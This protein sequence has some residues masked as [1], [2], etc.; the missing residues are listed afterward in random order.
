MLSAYSPGW[1]VVRM[2]RIMY[3]ESRCQ[4]GARNTSSSATGLLQILA[5]HCGW[6]SDQMNTW[7][8]RDRLTNPYFN[9]RAAATLWREQS[10]GAWSTS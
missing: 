1:D 6:L 3:R 9:V 5:S 4:A 10:Y 7:C 8:T 2:S